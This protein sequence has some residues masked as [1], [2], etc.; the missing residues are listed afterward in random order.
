MQFVH[1]DL[2][3]PMRKDFAQDQ[4]RHASAKE[5]ESQE[6]SAAEITDR[7]RTD[8]Q[9]Y[10]SLLYGRDKLSENEDMHIL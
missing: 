1:Q 2:M 3:S 9:Y 10:P 6:R 8:F 5:N 7:P 4:Q